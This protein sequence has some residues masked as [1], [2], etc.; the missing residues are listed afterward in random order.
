ML[1]HVFIKQ[2]PGVRNEG[3]YRFVFAVNDQRAFESCLFA[4]LPPFFWRSGQKPTT[5]M[6]PGGRIDVFVSGEGG[7]VT[8]EDLIGWVS[9]ASKSVSTYFGRYPAP[10]VEV[11]ITTAEGRGVRHG[12]TFGSPTRITISVGRDTTV[13]DLK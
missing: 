1:L 9:A 4:L 12:R 13:A 2:K 11:R 5:I 8:Q 6:T 3:K 10:H 7:A